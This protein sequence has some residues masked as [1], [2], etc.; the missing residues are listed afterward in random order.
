MCSTLAHR[1]PNDEGYYIK[2]GVGLGIRRLS[3]I[4]SETGHQPVHNED[5]SVQVVLNGEIY[6]SPEL[7]REL[8]EQGCRFH[9]GTDDEVIVRL[10]EAHGA[11][12]VQRLRGMFAFALWD[13]RRQ[14]LLLVRDRIGIKPIFYGE[15]EGRFVFGSEI[16]A[17]LQLPWM[18]REI[19]WGSVSHLFTFLTTPPKESILQGIHKLEPGQ[20]L[21]VRPS[22][23]PRVRTWW[24][25][26][27]RPDY[28]ST[29]EDFIA[30][31]RERLEDSVKLRMRSD[32]PAGAFLSGGIVSSAVV[33]AMAG[34]SPERVK[35]FSIGFP[36]QAYDE[37]EPARRVAEVFDTDHHEL[38]LDPDVLGLVEDMAWYLDEPFG[39]SSA[40]PTYMLSKL[41]ADHVSVVLSGDG[42]DELFAG[43]DRQR[44]EQRQ[45]RYRFIPHV[46]RRGR[47]GIAE[48]MAGGMQGRKHL[49]HLDIDGIE[50]Y[51]D[52]MTMVRDE[53]KL[54]LFRPEIAAEM[55][56]HDAWAAATATLNGRGGHWLSAVQQLDIKHY[57]PL[58]ILTRV[59]RMS[60]A[61]SLEARVPLL[62]HRMVEFAA[63]IPPE[64]SLDNGSTRGMFKR[65]MQGVLPDA[66]LNRSQRG[67][68]VPLAKWFRG[69]LNRLVDE[70]LLSDG[71][72]VRDIFNPDYVETLLRM[73]R[74]GRN[75]DLHLWTMIS[76]ELWCRTFLHGPIHVHSGQS[77]IIQF[78]AVGARTAGR[79]AGT[80][81]A[82]PAPA[83]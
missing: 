28:A 18:R 64:M 73:H 48:M 46:V 42:G 1:G 13:A 30:G 31:I 51:L 83:G 54:K 75:L 15:M 66:I 41:A 76:F 22:E 81:A 77:R 21:T 55:R 38:V 49:R 3:I 50:R 44:M 59:D 71:S 58:D 80:A 32:Q 6:N 4:D 11:G 53:D 43:Y 68:G 16:K 7:R 72:N 27:F 79:Y 62:D 47:G 36:G 17:L 39:D 82:E 24:D 5:Q 65:A 20:L 40:I 61:H 23:P 63:T 12:C 2:N 37:S 35:T 25:V 69:G 34:H 10:Y 67:F 74:S 9:T 8:E 78:P 56:G 60:M 45:R 19:N 33:A 29:E 26:E 14:Q 52:A 70:L 57:L